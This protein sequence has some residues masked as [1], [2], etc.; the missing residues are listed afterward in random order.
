MSSKKVKAFNY[1]SSMKA[2][3]DL[4]DSI[5]SDELDVDAAI[6]KF[7]EGMKLVAELETYL[8]TAENKIQNIKKQFAAKSE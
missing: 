8:N 5:E 4:L 6:A 2:L 3:E 7:E 1:G